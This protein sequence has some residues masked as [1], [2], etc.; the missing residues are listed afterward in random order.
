MESNFETICFQI[1]LVTHCFGGES[2]TYPPKGWSKPDSSLLSLRG[3][4]EKQGFDHPW[5]GYISDS[6]PK[7]WVTILSHDPTLIM[8]NYYLNLL[9]I[10]Q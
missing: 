7:Q 5:G 8:I 6:Q 4:L 10:D 9:F 2:E 1:L 3:R